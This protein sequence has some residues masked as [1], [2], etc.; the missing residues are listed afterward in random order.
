MGMGYGKARAKVRRREVR[1]EVGF[2]G[3][4]VGMVKDGIDWRER[5]RGKRGVFPK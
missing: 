2:E 4:Q 3:G 1:V 5:T